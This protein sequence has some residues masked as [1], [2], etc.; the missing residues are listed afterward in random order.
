MTLYEINS[1]ILALVD[2]DGEIA[3]FEEF[4]KLML[5]KEEK[6]ENVALYYK[7]LMAEAAAIKNEEDALKKRRIASENK[8]ESLKN[9]L[10]HALRGEKFKSARVAVSYRKSTQTVF[11]DEFVKWA[12]ENA[13]DLLRYAEPEPKKSEIKERLKNGEA[14]PHA[15]LRTVS[16]ITVR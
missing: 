14:I 13:D 11:D 4:D 15:A 5:A 8:A 10:N 6:I 2:E 12:E 1:A 7:N 3:D 16:N 9:Y